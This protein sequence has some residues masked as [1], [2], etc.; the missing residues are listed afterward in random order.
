[1]HNLPRASDA[2]SISLQRFKE[3]LITNIAAIVR[4]ASFEKTKKT[5]SSP[6][7]L[8]LRFNPDMAKIKPSKHK[9][10]TST[11]TFSSKNEIRAA[12]SRPI[13]NMD[14][15]SIFQKTILWQAALLSCKV[16]K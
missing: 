13:A 12:N 9:A 3:A 14:S 16:E 2:C 11:L 7:H 4:G 8:S 15:H 6:G 10:V 1:L 5:S